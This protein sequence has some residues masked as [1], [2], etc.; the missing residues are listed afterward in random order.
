MGTPSSDPTE[1]LEAKLTDF[2]A[3]LTDDELTVFHDV[4]HLAAD[5][6][7][8]QGFVMPGLPVGIT[9]DP[10]EG[11]EVTFGGTFNMLGNL[12]VAIHQRAPRVPTVPRS[13]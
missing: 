12:H 9:G 2:M 3:T 11:G 5:G 8:V 13:S 4:V 1:T 6:G 7:D 10:C